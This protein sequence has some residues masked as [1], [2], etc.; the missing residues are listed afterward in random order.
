[1]IQRALLFIALSLSQISHAGLELGLG[2]SA[3]NIPH[4]LGSNE[5]ETHFLP[6]PYLRYRS[7]TINIDRSL[8]QTNLWHHGNWSLELSLGGAFKV[9]SD[10]SQARKGMDDLDF[11][12]EVGPAL[13]YYFLGDRS[14]DNAMFIELPVRQALST[15]FSQI[16]GRGFSIN[17]RIIWRRGYMIGPYEVR[18]ELSFGLRNGNEQH[19]NY[20]YG[21]GN[22]FATEQRAQY[23]ANSGYGGWQAGYSTAVL[24]NN[25]LVAGFMRYSNINGAAFTDSPLVKQTDNVLV[26]LAAAMLF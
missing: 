2:M 24:W 13:H 7:E 12:L 1:M 18:P 11:M 5:A 16:H 14:K 21:V 19:H 20:I 6:F 10:K 25:W 4:Y 3:A 17:P 23:A 22:E 26:G 9:D 8:I 15:D